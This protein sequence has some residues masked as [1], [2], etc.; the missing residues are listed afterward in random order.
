MQ[1]VS[2]N[3]KTEAWRLVD[4]YTGPVFSHTIGRMRIP[5]VALQYKVGFRAIQ[6][7]RYPVP[8]HYQDRMEV[9]LR[10]LKKE[11]VIEDVNPAEP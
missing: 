6:P 10:K 4:K 9:H 7:P 3:G 2:A 5:P 11:S 1:F 8:N